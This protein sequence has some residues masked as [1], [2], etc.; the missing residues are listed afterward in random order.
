MVTRPSPPATRKTPSRGQT[1]VCPQPNASFLTLLLTLLLAPLIHARPSKT[2]TIDTFCLTI[3]N[4]FL[5]STP[6]FF[7]GPDPW[8]RLD[9]LPNT[10]SD[11]AIATVYAEGPRIKWVVL[12]MQGPDNAWYETTNYFF[13]EDGFL[14]KRERRLNQYSSDIQVNESFYFEKRKRIKSS[15]HHQRLPENDSAEKDKAQAIPSDESETTQ[16]PA[17]LACPSCAHSSKENWDTF[18]DPGAPLYT[19][20]ADLPEPFLKLDFKQLA[21]LKCPFCASS[22][23]PL[24]SLLKFTRLVSFTR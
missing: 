13:D 7:S 4:E 8:V 22:F 15:F 3:R 20:T 14:Q 18:Y 17:A 12:E 23:D 10:F 1:S 21:S 11:A 9:R 6:A 2:A 16:K 5:E 19:S 24:S